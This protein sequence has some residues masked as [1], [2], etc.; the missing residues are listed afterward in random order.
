[1]R[2]SSHAALVASGLAVVGVSGC[3][4]GPTAPPMPREVS[5]LAAQ[6]DAAAATLD[7]SAAQTIL[8][9]TQPTQKVLR[10]F[11]GLQFFRDI[12][13]DATSLTPDAARA[14]D[15]RGSI[16]AHA[17]CPGWNDAS[18]RDEDDATRG[19]IDVTIGVEET[20]VQR[21]FTGHATRCQFIARQ[22]GANIDVVVTMDLQVDL[23][24]DIGLGDAAP[25]ILVR[26][27]NASGM[28]DGVALDLERRVFSFRLDRDGSIETLVDLA[29]LDPNLRGSVLL[30]LRGDGT[31]S[32]R[33]REGEWTCDSTESAACMLRSAAG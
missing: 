2:S 21:A 32:L 22:S 29:P 33:S 30:A 17:P 20:R 4:S 18:A 23:G 12:V 5:A 6:Y 3:A 1:M 25:A 9:Q 15:V 19:F 7:A 24:G 14:L 16:D 28:V 26:A 8:M 27:T 10:F 31:W 11:T 13:D